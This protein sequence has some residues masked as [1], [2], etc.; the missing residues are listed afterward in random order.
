MI[1]PPGAGLGHQARLADA[2]LAVE[3]QHLSGL[4][5]QP[6]DRVLQSGQ[7]RGAADEPRLQPWNAARFVQRQLR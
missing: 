2:G 4:V 7:F 3:E 5:C 6:I 1:L